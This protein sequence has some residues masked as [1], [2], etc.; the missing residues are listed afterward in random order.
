MC[1][2]VQLRGAARDAGK[3]TT[4]GHALFRQRFVSQMQ[5]EPE[6]REDLLLGGL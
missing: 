6:G 1:V 4:R 5:G 3:D 2:A